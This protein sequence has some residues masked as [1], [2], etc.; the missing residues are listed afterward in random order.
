MQLKQPRPLT[1]MQAMLQCAKL[2][3][4]REGA[5]HAAR[6]AAPLTCMQAMPPACAMLEAP[7]KQVVIMRFQSVCTDAPSCVCACVC[8]C[9]CVCMCVSWSRWASCGCSPCA[10]TRHPVGAVSE[11]A[12]MGA[13]TGACLGLGVRAQGHGQAGGHEDWT[14]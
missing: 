8:V 7:L 14:H 9:V 10:Q 13:S 12:S 6:A 2:E 4:V 1:C 3:S 5:T 11:V